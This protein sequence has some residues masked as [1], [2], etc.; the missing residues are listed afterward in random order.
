MMEKYFFYKVW[1]DHG[2]A[3]E[4]IA[5]FVDEKILNKCKLS[6]NRYAKSLDCKLKIEEYKYK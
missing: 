5:T 2:V 3:D 6:L 1:L 4:L